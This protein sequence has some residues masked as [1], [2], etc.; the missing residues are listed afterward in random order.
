MI[1]LFYLLTF[2]Y[3][4]QIVDGPAGVF[5]NTI[6][7]DVKGKVLKTPNG[8][9]FYTFLD[10]PYATPPVES[11]RFKRPL[12]PKP[13][14]GILDATENK[15]ICWNL[16]IIDI[17][18][19]P[20]QNE[21]CLYLNVYVPKSPSNKG[22]L[23]VM[24]YITG[25]MFAF[26]DGTFNSWKPYNFIER[27][28]IMVAMNFRQGPLGLLTTND[29]V[30][31]GNLALWDQN[32]ALKWVQKNI[33]RFG[34]DPK[35]VTINGHSSG[36][37]FATA[38][39]LSKHSKGLFSGVIAQS[40]AIT[41][42]DYLQPYPKYNAYKLANT[43]NPSITTQ[44]TS[45]ELLAFLMTVPAKTLSDTTKIHPDPEHDTRVVIGFE[46]ELIWKPVMEPS[47]DENV[48]FSGYPDDKFREGIFNKVP[49]MVGITSEE[50]ALIGGWKD[51][52]ELI[53]DHPELLYRQVEGLTEREK[54]ELGEKMIRVYTEGKLEKNLSAAVKLYSDVGF[55]N[56]IIKFADLVSP[57]VDVY[58]YQ[59]SFFGAIENKAGPIVEMEGL[60]KAAHC[61]EL[62]YI[63][64]YKLDGDTTVYPEADMRVRRIV[65]DLFG[66]FIKYQNPTPKRDAQLQNII[67]PKFDSEQLRFLDIDYNLTVKENPR[68]YR[69]T[70]KLIY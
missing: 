16:A 19:D 18:D 32:M 54:K 28:I 48:F 11:L 50:G 13:W 7:G 70:R 44:N 60:G 6:Y 58:F 39:L 5:A 27:D 4:L 52:I 20:R 3:R 51:R 66:N 33:E 37:A 63:I 1:F 10:I 35:K 42:M 55:S 12:P 34:G 62:P 40:G 45:E 68:G 36:G 22:L 43:I 30:I 29:G 17:E 21:D 2:C 24:F 9:E 65:S 38:H 49:V 57:Y 8:L 47:D 23:P 25:G 59:Y 14:K 53:D 69:Q 26:N 46:Y 31:P 56:R 61:A 41:G 15:K 67:W 64:W